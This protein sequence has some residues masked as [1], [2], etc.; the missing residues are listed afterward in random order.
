MKTS[1]TEQEVLEEAENQ[2]VSITKRQSSAIA[3]LVDAD[4]EVSG[5]ALNRK[6]RIGMYVG[7]ALGLAALGTGAG[8]L[9][10]YVHDR[11]SG[12]EQG[13]P[14]PAP[15]LPET[16]VSPASMPAAPVSPTSAPL[17]LAPKPP[18]PVP[19]PT[20]GS[21]QTQPESGP[22]VHRKFGGFF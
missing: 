1:T 21:T 10:K 19:P 16:P 8:V 9:G 13:D 7:I 15:S 5:G 4:L 17:I 6:Q 14:S 2:G 11:R 20:S 18:A 12:G 3:E 22:V